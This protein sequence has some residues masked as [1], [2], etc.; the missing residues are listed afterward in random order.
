MNVP[1]DVRKCVVFLGRD[2]DHGIRW[3]A[4]GFFVVVS[5]PAEDDEADSQYS[6]SYL[7]TARHVIDGIRDL[8]HEGRVYVRLNLTSGGIKTVES[9]LSDWR[10]HPTK[11]VDAAALLVPKSWLKELDHSMLTE[12][13]IADD[14]VV[15]DHGIG[16][17]QDVF[18]TGLFINH[19]GQRRN[20]PIIRVGNIAAMPE[21]KVR[22]KLDRNTCISAHAYLI[23][24]RSIKGLS[25]SPVFTYRDSWEGPLTGEL[26]N[27]S[28]YS[29]TTGSRLIDQ[30]PIFTTGTPSYYWL[31]LVHGHWDVEIVR[32]D[33]EDIDDGI[34]EYVNTG[35]A[36]VVPATDVWEVLDHPDFVEHRGYLA[37]RA[38]A[39]VQASP[40]ESDGN[41]DDSNR[42]DH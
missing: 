6:H 3:C 12:Y 5:Q 32:S 42:A 23:E 25:G 11:E 38:V 7:I 37:K 27:M 40:D 30:T 26:T 28:N 31:G 17:G 4:T 34:K 35:I 9:Q 19:Y 22:M 18:I 39:T 21:E 2:T 1:S 29:F 24:L 33:I 15:Q 10:F 36:I 20:I 13:S 14:A 16:P 8:S 41:V